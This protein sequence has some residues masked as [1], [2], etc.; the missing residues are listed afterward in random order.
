MLSQCTWKITDKHNLLDCC[1]HTVFCNLS[2]VVITKNAEKDIDKCLSSVAWIKNKIIVDSGSD[3]HTCDIAREHDALVIH[4]DWMGFGPQK[5]FAVEQS[6]TDWVLCLDADEFLSDELVQNIKMLF[7][8]GDSLSYDA[9]RIPR[10]NKFLGRFLRHGEGYPDWSLRLFNKQKANWSL[11][12]VHEKVQAV[13]RTMRVGVLKGDLLHNS[14]E[15]ITQYIEK[16]NRYTDIQAQEIF[17]QGKTVS[18]RHL[19]LNPAVRFIKY[20]FVKLGCLDGIAGF[21]HITIGC[22]FVYL[23]YAKVMAYQR[24]VSGH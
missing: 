11:D 18:I 1:M 22:I 12:L 10:S 5:R 21:I 20:F 15:S 6:P 17:Q 13:D 7:K 23:K 2:V 14:A 9:Y 19:L 24:K 16:Q 8:D 3:D 4:K